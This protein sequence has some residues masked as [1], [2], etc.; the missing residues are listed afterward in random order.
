[1][2][3]FLRSLHAQLTTSSP[4]RIA[5]LLGLR[6]D[7]AEPLP[8]DLLDLAARSTSR[9]STSSALAGFSDDELTLV[10]ALAA[11]VVDLLDPAL[12]VAEATERLTELALLVDQRLSPQVENILGPTPLGLAPASM[13]LLDASAT[14]AALRGLDP[15]ARVVLDRL[16][17]GNPVGVFRDGIPTSG[18]VHRLLDLGLLLQTDPTH[19][20]APRATVLAVRGQVLVDGLTPARVHAEVT[21]STLDDPTRTSMAEWLLA[22]GVSGSMLLGTRHLD[23]AVAQDRWVRLVHAHEDGSVGVDVVRVLVVAQGSAHTVRRA[24]KRLSVPV[25]RIVSVELLEPVVIHDLQD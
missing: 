19:V 21:A 15:D 22:G 25:A 3:D 1:M 24:G 2:P 8:S 12:P 23:E 6:P 10:A 18:P 17:A 9:R 7:L 13:D 5:T 11:G 14:T 16:A 4:E 20:L